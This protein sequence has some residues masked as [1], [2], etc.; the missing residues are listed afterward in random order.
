MPSHRVRRKKCDE[1]RPACGQ[2][3]ETNRSC[4]FS[5]TGHR[6]TH[7]ESDSVK[8]KAPRTSSAHSTRTPTEIVTWSLAS[9]GA[10]SKKHASSA[11]LARLNVVSSTFGPENCKLFEYF[12]L[13]VSPSFSGGFSVTI[14]DQVIPQLAASGDESIKNA[15]LAISVLHKM[16]VQPSET[17]NMHRAISHYSRSL[18]T[19]NHRLGEDEGSHRL[20]ALASILFMIIEVLRGNDAGAIM[21]VDGAFR[22]LQS[23]KSQKG[24]CSGHD[25]LVSAFA[26]LDCQATSF[27]ISWDPRCPIPVCVP[28]K[29][30]T[31]SVAR[32]VLVSI[33][34]TMHA[35]LRPFG[36]RYKTLP[37]EPLPVFVASETLSI[38]SHLTSWYNAFQELRD[39]LEDAHGGNHMS[40]DI[41]QLQYLSTW[42]EI[43]CWFQRQQ[44]CFDAYTTDH[45]RI[46]ELGKKVIHARNVHNSEVFAVDMGII[47]PLYATACRCRAS[48][49]RLEALGLLQIAG[50]E[51]VW[52]GKMLASVARWVIAQEEVHRSECGF[53]DERWRLRGAGLVIDRSRL[54]VEV[55]ANRLGETGCYETLQGTVSWEAHCPGFAVLAEDF[56]KLSVASLV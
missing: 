32:D 16:K 30:A 52:N 41:L 36:Q 24:R 4:D 1:Q 38:Q 56:N 48:S 35:K 23:M 49:T 3:V 39:E 21:H 7:H 55:S 31:I 34:A 29:F 9:N 8:L 42:I 46:V 12:C 40:M 44:I 51:G 14:W 19:L 27:A 37:A 53:I 43:Q 5:Q 15:V 28:S 18:T 22:I 10:G 50:C 11:S 54:T 13:L 47:Q 26:R 33:I 6:Q 20:A 45:L 2:C 17:N 25:E